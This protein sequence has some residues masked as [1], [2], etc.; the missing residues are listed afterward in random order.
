LPLAGIMKDVELHISKRQNETAT[1][2][3]YGS[4]YFP[5]SLIDYFLGENEADEGST[6]DKTILL[7]CTCG[8]IGC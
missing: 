2:G 8:S 6:E 5:A 3:N 4:L 1:A 7:K